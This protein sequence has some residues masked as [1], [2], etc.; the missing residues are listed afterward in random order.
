MPI[1]LTPANLTTG[2]TITEPRLAEYDTNDA[3][4]ATFANQLE[5]TISSTASDVS[6]KQAAAPATGGIFA[7]HDGEWMDIDRTGSTVYVAPSTT[8]DKQDGTEF[9]PFTDLQEAVDSAPFGAVIKLLP[10][11]HT[12]T[13]LSLVGRENLTF[14][15]DGAGNQFRV[16]ISGDITLTGASHSIE[17]ANIA[18]RGTVDVN[19]TSERIYFT[20]CDVGTYVQ[21]TT[22]TD[23]YIKFKDCYVETSATINTGY[24][25]FIAT[26]FERNAVLYIN[27]PG[28]AVCKG[29][30]HQVT[31]IK[32]GGKYYAD[33]TVTYQGDGSGVCITDTSDGTD[34]SLILLGGI[35]NGIDLQ[36][37]VS[38][39]T[40]NKTGTSPYAI[41]LSIKQDT[42]HVLNGTRLPIGVSSDDIFVP[43]ITSGTL[44]IP[45]G[46]L[47]E[48]LQALADATQA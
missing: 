24:C 7:I 38:Q 42:G 4:L 31:L 34:D 23:A 11:T 1:S 18:I 16:E 29:G 26:Q 14:E 5:T 39:F 47:T 15:A 27:D 6:T 25:D 2:E 37:Q 8:L 43:E 35:F 28:I 17:F 30:T 46:T 48:T 45:A 36:G 21:N 10:G 44:T 22:A 13:N 40:I 20:G 33:S 19:G 9:F 3:L 12:V 41:T 32:S